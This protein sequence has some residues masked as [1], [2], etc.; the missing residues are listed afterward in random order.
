MKGHRLKSAVEKA[1]RAGPK[2]DQETS[3]FPRVGS[4][5]VTWTVLNS[6]GSDV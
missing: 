1:H 5:G 3:G 2:G 4:R 6:P